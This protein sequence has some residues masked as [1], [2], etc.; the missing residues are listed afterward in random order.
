[1][2]TKLELRPYQRDAVNSIHDEFRSG[3]RSTLL[4]LPTGTGKTVVFTNVGRTFA[5]QSRKPIL[6]L[7]HRTELLEQAS[8]SLYSH[9]LVPRLEKA[10]NTAVGTRHDAVV[11]SVQTLS[12][13]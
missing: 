6:V 11:A 1:M 5:S 3:V 12:R 8:N 2:T 7:A 9:G 13:P 10:Q 4:V